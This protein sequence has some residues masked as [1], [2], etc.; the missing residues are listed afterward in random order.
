M[1]GLDPADRRVL[2]ERARLL[3]RPLPKPQA[4]L[5]DG[6]ELLVFMRSGSAYAVPVAKVIEI[7]PLA[8]LTPVPWV[9]AAVLGVVNH[10]GR[11]VPLVDV[12]RL[13]PGGGEEGDGGF[14][15][16]LAA[17]AATLALHADAVAGVQR[18]AASEVRPG[19]DLGIDER[20]TIVRGLTPELAAILDVDALA[21]DPRLEV[22]DEIE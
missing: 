1:T 6:L 9:P 18:L 21:R 19:A 11:I 13:L 12:V 5:G 2:E 17:G 14:A 4:E 22:N 8:A 20:E 15:V 10:R 3:A 16:V 7:V